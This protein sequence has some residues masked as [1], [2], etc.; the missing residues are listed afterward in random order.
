MKAPRNGLVLG[1]FMP[2]H[3][4][5]LFLCDFAR[6]ACDQLTILVCSLPDD[7]LPGERRNVWM[8]E[9]YP[10]CR[11]VWCNEVV[12][13]EPSE[14]PDFWPIWRDLI[15]RH[16][17]PV[18]AVFASED[19]G[20]PLAAELDAQFIPCDPLRETAAVSATSIR[21]DP[22]GQWR[23]IARPARPWFAK[24]VC[25]FGP[26]SSGKTTLSRQLAGALPTVHLPEYGR[27]WTDTFGPDVDAAALEA[28]AR[29]HVAGRAAALK[30]ADRILIEDTDP[31]LTCVWSD[32]LLGDRQ[33]W[34][35]ETLDPADLYLLTDIDFDW[36][37]D[38]TR[39]F[40]EVEQRRR[41][42]TLCEQELIDRGL[43][44]IPLSGPPEVRL[45]KALSAIRERFGIWEASR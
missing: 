23:F 45:A 36:V 14:S 1:K 7:E 37:D 3:K 42:H 41:F 13:Q 8:R 22:F 28:I 32:M 30:L 20:H 21:A 33:H 44:F 29:G 6:A 31:I 25:V 10:D 2:P 27:I 11:V 34:M 39:Y 15:A 18:D 19:Y 4:G 38:G 12:P 43:P 35:S 24:R 5:H 40:P 26:E 17:G 9:L 16:V